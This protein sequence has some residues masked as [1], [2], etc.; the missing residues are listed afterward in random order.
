VFFQPAF[1]Q[2]T[3]P[4]GSTVNLNGGSLNLAGTS[5][6]VTGNFSTGSG[7]VDG[8]SDIDIVAPGVLDGG[9]GHV[10]LFGSWSD[11]GTFDAASGTVFFIDGASA[12]ANVSGNSTFNNASFVSNTGKSYVFAVGTTQT[13]ES[14]LTI[15]GTA[16][17]AIQF[18][19]STAGQVAN[20]DLLGGGTQSI[21]FVGVSDVH[22][23]G[24]HLAPTLSNDGGTGNAIGWFGNGIPPGTT[25][26]PIPTLSDSLLLLMGLLVIGFGLH[27]FRRF[28]SLR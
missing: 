13:V 9:S 10:S 25:A 1:A 18:K 20:I 6:S 2:F 17:A 15:A 21:S 26:A 27:N 4:T 14:A 16:A 11:A 7:G 22:A 12:S 3:V 8:A 28:S 19:S 23:T 5:L 24:Q